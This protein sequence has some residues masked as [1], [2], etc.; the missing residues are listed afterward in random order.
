MELKKK[1]KIAGKE[2]KGECAF[3][4]NVLQCELFKNGYGIKTERK[5]I[6]QLLECQFKH[7]DKRIKRGDK[8]NE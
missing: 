5:N 7:Y 1:M 6:S 2:I 4:G 3:C 8:E